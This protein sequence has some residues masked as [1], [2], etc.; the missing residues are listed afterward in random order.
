MATQSER[1]EF[2]AKLLECPTVQAMEPKTRLIVVAHAAYESGWGVTR[3]AREDFNVFN[4]TAGSSWTGPTSRG[5]DLEYNK[6]GGHRKIEQKW[7]CYE[8]L[9]AA[10]VDYLALLRKPRYEATHV[11]ESLLAGHE[12][13][14][15]LGLSAAGYFTLP[16]REY[17][18]TF[19]SVMNLVEKIINAKP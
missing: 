3:Q 2:V 12:T 13:K 18:R 17:F 4:V 14:F 6:Q 16:Y 9:D 11:M 10:V 5:M 15:I 19:N 7:R 8:S 1:A